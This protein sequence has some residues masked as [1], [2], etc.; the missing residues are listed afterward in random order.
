MAQKKPESSD[1]TKVRRIKAVDNNPKGQVKAKTDKETAVKNSKAKPAKPAKRPVKKIKD[2][3][4]PTKNPLKAFLNYLRGSWYELKQVRWPNRSAT[5]S[6]T[7]AVLIFTA[8]FVV[9][10][11]LLDIGFNWM[12]EQILK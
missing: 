2:F 10:I 3:N 6:M 12:F 4:T 11:I 7:L 9:L 5:W 8:F 1:G